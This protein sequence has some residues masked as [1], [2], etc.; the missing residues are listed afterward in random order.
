[1]DNAV[2]I[3]WLDIVKADIDF[4]NYDEIN[5]A[6]NAERLSTIHTAKTQELSDKL[7]I[8]LLGFVDSNGNDINN[9]K[10]SEISG[11]DYIGSMMILCKCGE[12]YT[13]LPFTEEEIDMVY[14]YLT[15]GEIKRKKETDS[16]DS[17]IKKYNINP[18]LP[19]F[20]IEP[21]ITLFEQYPRIIFVKYD[22][23]H[24]NDK[25]MLKF[26]E[27]L[28][29]YSS[30]LLDNYT[31]YKQVNMAKDGSHYLKVYQTSGVMYVVIQAIHNSVEA[32]IINDLDF[33]NKEKS[34]IEDTLEEVLE[35]E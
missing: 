33:S 20:D 35:K 12:G 5:E 9:K 31:Q 7:G 14:T 17:F 10:A 26:G 27:S 8:H 30:R 4:S 15:T 11:Y 2:I 29:K 23:S 25:E 1:M 32:P 22:Y 13:P 6:I 34:E 21:Q 19:N 24:L 3:R 18:I 16:Y 28:F